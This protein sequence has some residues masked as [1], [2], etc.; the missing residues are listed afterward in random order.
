MG[1]PPCHL[2]TLLLLLCPAG[3]PF[4]ICAFNMQRFAG[5]KAAKV[6]VMDTLVKIVSRCD[7]MVLQEVLDAKGQA[8]PALIRALNRWV[9]RGQG[10][11]W[12][13]MEGHHWDPPHPVP[14][15]PQVRRPGLLRGPE[16]PAAGSRELPGALC[17]R[18]PVSPALGQG[19]A[20]GL[21]GR[22]GLAHG[23]SRLHFL[24]CGDPV[25]CFS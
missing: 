22:R 13:W 24:G 15:C 10:R 2:C 19:E 3:A 4:R 25:P 9:I 5:P 17:L 11:R 20:L 16:Q 18:V 21:A 14:S 12:G 6:T 7:I 23:P 8:V 1:L